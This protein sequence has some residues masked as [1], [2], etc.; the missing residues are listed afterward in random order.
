MFNIFSNFGPEIP[1]TL[2]LLALMGLRRRV[3]P[4][5][6][7]WINTTPAKLWALIDVY[8]GKTENWGRTIIRSDLVDATTQTFRKTYTTTQ[9]NGTVRPF[10][11]LFRI[12][13]HDTEK[14]IEL[15][16][17]GLEGRSENNE[18]LKISHSLVAEKDGTRLTTVYHWGSR[19]LI[20]QLLARTDLWSGA[21]RLKGQAE[22]GMPNE[23]PFVLISLGVALVTG[24]LTLGGFILMLGLPL[25][26][27]LIV[28]LF[29]HEF[30]HLLA[31]RLLGQPWGRLVFL[32]FLGAMAM[33]RLGFESQA[34]AVFSALMG[35]G[36]SILL[37]I[38]CATPW[39]LDYQAHPFLGGLGIITA[40]LNIFNMLPAEPLDGGIALRSV[41][42]RLMGDY[43]QYGLIAV[44]VLIASLGF[45]FDQFI[46]VVFGGLAIIA[47]LK[48][49]KIDAGL[50]SL[51]TVQVWICA[52]GYAA[53]IAAHFA[54]LQYLLVH[55]ATLQS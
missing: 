35:P 13:Q 30:G 16:R 17:V 46:L 51:S 18:L 28:V 49:R 39:I 2:I 48:V 55:G 24:L 31:F 41:L 52:F 4:K 12:N 23:R 25:A 38:F 15:D 44:G 21:W 26:L 37:T 53:I 7:L 45:S 29:V 43:A 1:F 54:L 50:K 8:D 47:N 9:P 27:L 19:P 5:T 36:F 10:T 22:T 3:T 40:L 20:A 6:S 42:T 34:Q 32:P 11:A 33:P 14:Y